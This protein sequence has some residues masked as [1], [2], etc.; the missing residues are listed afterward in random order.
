MPTIKEESFP[1]I[2]D[3]EELVTQQEDRRI[4]GN[5]LVAQSVNTPAIGEYAIGGWRLRETSL[6]SSSGAVGLSS[7]VTTGVDWRFWAGN[8]TAS[9][10]PFRV[11]ESGNL[12]A[13]S[14]TITGSITAT[15][16]TIGGWTIGA[17][18]LVSGTGATTTGIDSAGI[19]PAFYAGSATPGSAPFRVTQAGALTATSATISGAITA[20]SGTIGGWIITT[21]GIST[22]ATEANA[23]VLINK[24]TASIRLG[25][26]SGNYIT[27]DG[28]NQRIRSSNYVTGVAGSGFN[29]DSDL[30][31]AGNMAVRGVIRSAV[32]QKD[33]VSAVGGNLLV[34]PSDVLDTDMTA[35]DS[36]TLT[37][38]GSETFAVGDFLQIKDGVDSEWFEVT[39]IASA[40][41]YTVTRDKDA[42]YGADANPTWKKGATVVNFG[43][44]G[45]GGIYLTSSETNAP[46]MSVFTHAGVPWDTLTTRLRVGNLNGY[47]DY[48]TDIYG[49]AVGDSSNYI[50]VDPTNN[51]RI[52]TSAANAI[53]I[54]NGG[55]ILLKE[56]GDLYFSVVSS[57]GAATAA[58]I[59]AAGNVEA[60]TR[61]YKI[62]Y[63]SSHGETNLG[64]GSNTVITDGTHQQV[65][66]SNIPTSSSNAVTSRNIYRTPAS[67]VGYFYLG[68]IND[69]TTTTY[70]DNISDTALGTVLSDYKENMTSGS[71]IFK[72]T[73]T[74]FF[75]DTNLGIGTN[76]LDAL[77][78]S[79][80]RYNIAFGGGSGQSIEGGSYN[81]LYG[82][83]SGISI[84]TGEGNVFIGDS[85]G[86]N[87]TTG[88]Y[89]V[90][91]GYRAETNADSDS[92]KLIIANS[93]SI[94]YIP[95][96]Q[97]E[98]DN[99]NITLTG[100]Q[101]IDGVND[102]IQLTIQGHSTQTA[103]LTEWQNSSADVLA[104]VSPTG[105][106]L[107]GDKV[108][109][110]Q[111]DGNEYID[112]LAD[113]Y[114]DIGATTGIRLLQSTTIKNGASLIINSA[115]D[116][117]NVTI[118]HD[119]TNG[120][121]TCSGDLYI[122]PA[123]LDI[124]LRNG[125]KLGIMSAGND[126][127]VQLYHDDTN[128]ILL[129][130]SGNFVLKTGADGNTGSDASPN[131]TWSLQDVNGD[132]MFKT[133]SLTS[134][135]VTQILGH[136]GRYNRF[137][138]FDDDNNSRV[139]LSHN[140]TNGTVYATGDMILQAVGNDIYPDDAGATNLGTAAN[141][142]A[143]V[144]YKTL[145]D[146]GCLGFFDEGVEMPDG[147]TYSDLTAL[148][149]IKVRDDEKKTIYG[150]PM[151]DYKSFPV[152]SYK[153][154][155]KKG[156]LI[157]R[158]KKD[159][160]IEGADGIE[161]TSMFSIMI[162]A[163]KEINE[164]LN[165]LESK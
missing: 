75:S 163:F 142:F 94:G 5:M 14:A 61:I 4:D 18:S 101:V 150:K 50:S 158:N 77:L 20:T 44:S 124:S 110:T 102:I 23:E 154:A 86:G 60:G 96:I 139:S 98:F 156:K 84:T 10:A 119:D 140:G 58:L 152:V 3:K 29:I 62:T 127:Y 52:V 153:K 35:A 165:K 51:L 100:N 9:S 159:E 43:A 45:E 111:T 25:A 28:D 151:L 54:N 1:E 99:K 112:S 93:N 141:Y 107:F 41:T 13:S 22:D 42:Q 63:I 49:F 68:S 104:Y 7:E 39:D 113:G 59:T 116:D 145:T 164:R 91:I 138:V 133:I 137:D 149:M 129:G 125:T 135:A 160:P 40:P 64:I 74:S 120:Q 121:I 67:G 148:S 30:I 26:T 131:Q 103:N 109:F 34:R 37:I 132:E 122:E 8:A 70:T 38:S 89:N 36:S 2:P 123:G 24:T 16:G 88:S 114:L 157:K 95:L 92:N 33:V 76:V 90:C 134:M 17:T 65:S 72:T 31:E 87:T 48:V 106:A 55:N 57:A 81:V 69:N 128:P 19:N 162:G 15:T 155:D 144:S 71:L 53:T 143:D 126:K 83:S 56:G 46:Y 78:Y 85:A 12:V 118:S 27:I 108:A 11:D 105:G 47:L 146:R 97:G 115:G 66:L 21:N 79:S 73:R 32:F 6:T 80:G 147:K 136:N 130:S 161:M 117:K 82:Y